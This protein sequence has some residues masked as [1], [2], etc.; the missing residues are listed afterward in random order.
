L[1]ASGAN[2]LAYQWQKFNGTV[3]TNVVNGSGYSGATTPTLSINTTGNIGAGDYRC[4]VS[5]NLVSDVF[6]ATVSLEI[7]QYPVAEIDA[8]GAELIASPGDSYQWYKDGT[9]IAGAEGQTYPFNVVEYGAYTVD[10]TLS[11]CTSTSDEFIYLITAN[12][13]S[14]QG[15]TVSPNPFRDHLSIEVPSKSDIKIVDALGR[16]LK[17]HQLQG[18][19]VLDMNDLQPGAYILV[20]HTNSI[21]LYYRLIKTQ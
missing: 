2:N 7:N 16:E 20:I 19:A 18:H 15:V 1:S 6:S 17:H 9:Q 12:E 3:F 8:A 14:D 11:G 5:G 4:R 21:N 10:V 13:S